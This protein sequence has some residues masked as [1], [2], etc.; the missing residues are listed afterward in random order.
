[1]LSGIAFRLDFRLAQDLWGVAA[2]AFG[3][4]VP[5]S[6]FFA[7]TLSS[8]PIAKVTDSLSTVRGEPVEP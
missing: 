3:F 1:M 7:M 8:L 6:V 4:A 2:L 5:V